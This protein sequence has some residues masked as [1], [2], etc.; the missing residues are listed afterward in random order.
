[1][2]KN[3]K[4]LSAYCI[5]FNRREQRNELNIRGVWLNRGIRQQKPLMFN[6]WKF[7]RDAEEK[8]MF[9]SNE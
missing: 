6:D 2:K 9:T 7:G 4:E 8:L 1:M 5:S 3:T